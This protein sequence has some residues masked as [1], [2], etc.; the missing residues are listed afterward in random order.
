MPADPFAIP[1]TLLLAEDDPDDR[2]MI[3]R[4]LQRARPGLSTATVSDGIE[5]VKHL[6]LLA[7]DALPKLLLLDL[8]MP[9]MD[10]RQVLE[11]MRSEPRW[12]ALPIVVL[13]TSVE[14]EDVQRVNALGAAGFI[15]KPDE[16]GALIRVL[17]T[18][19]NEHLGPLSL[20]PQVLGAE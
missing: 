3:L 10:G 15:S 19:L 18:V 9:R 7:H 14:P 11:R 20:P 13:T 4:A 5:L 16:F 6:D 17:T 8:N 12:R 1:A 2:F